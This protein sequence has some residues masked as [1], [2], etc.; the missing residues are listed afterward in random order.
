MSRD[1]SKKEVKDLRDALFAL[2][3]QGCFR[4]RRVHG[5]LE[6]VRSA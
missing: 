6:W 4:E 3:E 2:R 1:V 5:F